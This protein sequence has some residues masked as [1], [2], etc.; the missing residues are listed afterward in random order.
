MIYCT[1]NI[2]S[3]TL[4]KF[5][6]FAQMNITTNELNINGIKEINPLLESFYVRAR[7]KFKKDNF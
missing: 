3:K 5:C 1:V 6:I 2:E 4:P 7:L